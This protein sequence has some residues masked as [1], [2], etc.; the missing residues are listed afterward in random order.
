MASVTT[1]ML[2][3]G[4]RVVLRA[5][6]PPEAE[7]LLFEIADIEL[8]ASEPGRVREH[9]YQTTVERARARLQQL[10]ITAELARECAVAM[11]PVLSAAYAR[12][13]GVR[14]VARYFGPLELFQADNFDATTQRYHGVFMDLPALV[15]DLGMPAAGV[16]LQALFLATLLEAESDETT[17]FLSTDTWTKHRKPGERTHKRASLALARPL[18]QALVELAAKGPQPVIRDQLARADI[19][20]F[21]RARADAAPDEEGREL[22]ASLERAIAV[23]DMPERGP[24]AEPD[25]WAIETRLDTG[26][27]ENILEAVE[28]VERSR[29]RTPGTT[30]L[31][32]RVSLTLHLEPPKL[33]AER[34]SALAL[35]MTSFQELCLLAAEAWLEAGDPRRAMPYARDL[36]DAPGIDEGLLLRAKRIL[37]RA[38]GAAPEKASPAH[39]TYADGMPTAPL[40]ASQRPPAVAASLPPIPPPD[41]NVSQSWPPAKIRTPLPQLEAPS[42]P[43]PAV[44]ASAP[45]QP[46]APRR[47]MTTRGM[48]IPP[49]LPARARALAPPIH[50]PMR[51]PAPSSPPVNLLPPLPPPAAPPQR[52]SKTSP[53]ASAYH[54]PPASSRPA[55]MSAPPP[56]PRAMPARSRPPPAAPISSMPAALRQKPGSA[57]VSTSA[58]PPP[59]DLELPPQP[60]PSASF[61][62]ELPGPESLLPPTLDAPKQTPSSAPRDGQSPSRRP[63]RRHSM[64]IV[65]VET[66]APPVYDPRAEPDSSE[67][68]AAPPASHAD[69]DPHARPTPMRPPSPPTPAPRAAR[70]PRKT[71][72]LDADL[73]PE[74]AGQAARVLEREKDI[75]RRA[76]SSLPAAPAMH[77]ASLPPFRL[78]EPPP[79]LAKAPLLP[80]LGGAADELA[81]HLPLPAGLGNEPRSLDRLPKSVL[82]A[83]VAFT[84]LARELG[85]DYRLKRGIELRADVSGIE[86]MQSVLLESFPDHTIR[87]HEDAYELRRHGALLSEILARRLDAEWID[88]SPNEAGYWAMIIP[89]DTRVWPFARVARLV[90]MGHRERDLVSFFFELQGRA[91]GR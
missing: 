78:E 34:V 12:G 77:G 31:R 24:L 71:P 60:D 41:F 6:A 4:D 14:H 65:S 75:Q 7:Y 56:P 11:H 13:P 64:G 59:I 80:R 40:P 89:P 20:A 18:E 25:L 55:P 52:K 67:M 70:E 32:A 82:E 50:T 87:T 72:M 83:R 62:L 15:G 37:A 17:V 90:E 73:G 43:P 8:R 27:L 45:S 19:I 51:P 74:S 9:G 10:G 61:T 79:L 30:Y 44:P 54:S 5:N 46:G 88:I 85:L 33:I 23:R 57:H 2:L 53:A 38:V 42:L 84:L 86:A 69:E 21:L 68:E 91:R 35:S 29:G 36:V 49:P 16:A 48:G 47:A 28:G 22:Y 81:E 39:Q 66:R 63:V 1:C 26:N 58:P 3:I 76:S